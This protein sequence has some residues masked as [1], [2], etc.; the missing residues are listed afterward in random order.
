LAK[1]GAGAIRCLTMN[2][3][4]F[5]LPLGQEQ[6]SKMREIYERAPCWGCRARNYP[7]EQRTPGTRTV[8]LKGSAEGIAAAKVW[9]AIV[10]HR[11]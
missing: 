7:S 4:H 9:K 11:K 1:P 5:T 2:R 10:W 3:E 8:V 6:A